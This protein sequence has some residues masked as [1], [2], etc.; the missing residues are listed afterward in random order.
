MF[1]GF[2]QIMYV[3]E[4][5]Y[6]IR[7]KILKTRLYV[8]RIVYCLKNNAFLYLENIV[9]VRNKDLWNLISRTASV[10]RDEIRA[11]SYMQTKLEEGVLS[12]RLFP[13]SRR[14]VLKELV[15]ILNDDVL[16]RFFLI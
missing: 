11:P 13:L 5:V 16:V 14:L 4:K 3:K 12:Q 10:H 7:I 8:L 9:C 2:I 15:A 6:R 1:T